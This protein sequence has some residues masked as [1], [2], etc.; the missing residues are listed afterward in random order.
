MDLILLQK[1]V[2][3]ISPFGLGFNP[4]FNGSN[5]STWLEVTWIFC[6]L[7]VSILIL[8][9]LILLPDEELRNRFRK[10]GF[11]PYFN[12]SN[13]STILRNYS[14]LFLLQCFNPYFNGSNT[15]T[16]LRNYS[17]LFLLQCFNPYFNGS[18]TSTLTHIQKLWA[19]IVVSILILMDLILLL[20]RPIFRIRH[21]N[22]FQS[23]F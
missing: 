15:S 11:N 8:M 7:D 18:N 22:M 4:Y 2:D 10:V 21:H 5:T 3:N 20:A 1:M 19:R 16:I 9:D 6:S 23:L 17:F 12:G 14:Y 13:T